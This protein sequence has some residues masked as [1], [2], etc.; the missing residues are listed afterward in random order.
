ML[1]LLKSIKYLEEHIK[2]TA[3]TI[4]ISCVMSPLEFSVLVENLI[5]LHQANERLIQMSA[6]LKMS[7]FDEDVT[8]SVS[9]LTSQLD[10]NEISPNN[11][12]QLKAHESIRVISQVLSLYQDGE[13]QDSWNFLQGCIDDADSLYRS[14]YE[15]DIAVSIAKSPF[16]NQLQAQMESNGFQSEIL[17]FMN[18][19]TFLQYLADD[20]HSD[21]YYKALAGSGRLVVA[22]GDWKT[23]VCGKYIGL[24][25]LYHFS[26]VA[27]TLLMQ[28]SSSENLDAFHG[29]LEKVTSPGIGRMLV[30]PVFFEVVMESREDQ[31]QS[32]V[33]G[34][35]GTLALF[36]ALLVLSSHVDFD[37]EQKVCNLQ[38]TGDKTLQSKVSLDSKGLIVDGNSNVDI[39]VESFMQFYHWAT[40]ERNRAQIAI[41]RKTIL[42][43]SAQFTDLLE[44]PKRIM[45]SAE[46]AFNLWVNQAVT[47]VLEINQRFTEYCLDWTHKDI[48][49]NLELHGITND[50]IL[51]GLGSIIG[52]IVGLVVQSF[53]SAASS[54]ILLII[55]YCL[56]AFFG[57]LI[58]R[59]EQLYTSFKSYLSQHEK[60]LDYYGRILGKQTIEEITGLEK[61][62]ELLKAFRKKKRNYQIF[63]VLLA[64][65]SIVIWFV[66]VLTGVIFSH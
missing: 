58:I 19:T 3:E 6:S 46:A 60:Q 40:D 9:P 11:V 18:T 43:Y 10:V 4:D 1:E 42:L 44:A 48:Q 45:M 54:I 22:I 25:D 15:W 39:A 30:N 16:N 34:R 37:E 62:F 61:P 59:T 49:M 47:E 20:F 26:D 23:P 31:H 36:Y 27:S 63:L 8:I 65:A 2:E 57:I 50:T 53:S 28:M 14:G 13:V 56:A 17:L 5:P 33:I 21:L 7:M 29:F 66:L 52:V 32:E 64:S 51:G 41:A 35:L 24:C 55:P 38:I 12:K